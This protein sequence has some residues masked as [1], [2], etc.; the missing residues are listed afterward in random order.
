MNFKDKKSEI[1]DILKTVF[2]EKSELIKNTNSLYS[3]IDPE[4]FD[5]S[6][7]DDIKV[8]KNIEKR[9]HVIK[10]LILSKIRTLNE[11]EVELKLFSTKLTHE[12]YEPILY[13][14]GSS[15]EKEIKF[16]AV[17]KVIDEKESFFIIIDFI[18]GYKLLPWS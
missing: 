9:L 8:T 13:L 3:Y 1:E 12:N 16:R 14:Y 10:D 2:Q 11:E 7:E 5:N 15:L 6:Y 18:N 17:P 4:F